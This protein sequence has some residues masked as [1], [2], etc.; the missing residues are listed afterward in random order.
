[1]NKKFESLFESVQLGNGVET[2]NR[3]AMAPM[4]VYGS[5][6]D[7]TVG[8]EDIDYFSIRNNTGGLIIT[9]AAATSRDG[10]GML[11]QLTAFDDNNIKGLKKLADVIKEKGNLAILQLH[12][13]G[14][15]SRGTY[16]RKGVVYAPSKIEF[17][18][19]DYVPEELTKDQIDEFIKDYGQATRRAIE[20]GFD[21][22]EIHGANHYMIQQFFS[23]YSNIRKDKW[24]GSLEKR[25][26]FALAV[27]DEV[28]SVVEDYADDTFVVGY[29]L[30]PEEVHG[31]NIGYTVNEAVKL[32][33]EIIKSGIGYIHLSMGKYDAMPTSG[34]NNEPIATTIHKGI[35]G[36]VPLMV[37]GS[38]ATPEDALDALK[39]ADIVALGRAVI[40]DPDFVVKLQEGK[41][42]AIEMSVENRFDSLRLP[43]MVKRFWQSEGSTLPPLKGLKG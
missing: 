3:F 34:G 24:G 6:D 23:E 31:E 20:A 35:D 41:E 1:M 19:L 4:L 30:S 43:E 37:A 32:V 33:N 40:I 16:K 14:R 28:N 39:Y 2:K 29:R 11:N 26:N 13:G 36:R 7:D 8:K 12:N 10:H 21:G 17:P 9:G 22:V 18:F 38:I 5:N 42:D 25:M 15:E 27:V